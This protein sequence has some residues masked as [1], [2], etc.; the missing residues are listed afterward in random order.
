MEIEKPLNMMM[1][2]ALIQDPQLLKDN[3]QLFNP[4]TAIPSE[5]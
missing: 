5:C 4:E 1:G 3:E 2:F